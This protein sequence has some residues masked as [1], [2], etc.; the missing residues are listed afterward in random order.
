MIGV[1]FTKFTANNFELYIGRA[2]APSG[3]T[4]VRVEVPF[5]LSNYAIFL[6]EG[7]II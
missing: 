2:T 6:Q 1:Y 4:N 5:D 7:L 3:G